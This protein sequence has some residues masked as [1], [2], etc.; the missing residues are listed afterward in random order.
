M[1]RIRRKQ[2]KLKVNFGNPGELLGSISEQKQLEMATKEFFENEGNF[3]VETE[4]EESGELC[5][6]PNPYCCWKWPYG[7]VGNTYRKV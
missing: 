4:A 3:D 2:L 5:L 7:L 1:R 6:T